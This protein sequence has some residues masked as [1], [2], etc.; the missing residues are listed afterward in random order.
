ME[1]KFK[2]GDR[3]VF[4]N[5]YGVCFGVKTI[6]SQEPPFTDDGPWRYQFEPTDTPWF[7][8]SEDRLTSATAEDEAAMLR[9]DWQHYFQ[10]K[11]GFETTREQREALLD[12]DPFEGE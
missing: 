2:P 8:K 1:H 12:T 10:T 9:E 4:T 3:V 6:T 5:E 11:Y 7:P